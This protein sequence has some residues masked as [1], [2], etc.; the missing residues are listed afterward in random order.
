MRCPDWINVEIVAVIPGCAIKRVGLAVIE[1]WSLA[2]PRYGAPGMHR[3]M[4]PEM[5]VTAGS[6]CG[7]N[8]PIGPAG[9]V[10]TERLAKLLQPSQ[11]Q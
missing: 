3:Q 7:T 6:R 11:R 8:W 10:L 2:N 4:L 1:S 9:A 5:L